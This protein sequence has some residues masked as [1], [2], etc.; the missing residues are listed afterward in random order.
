MSATHP[1]AVAA[2][3]TVDRENFVGNKFSAV[4]YDDENEYFS[5]SNNKN[6]A[7]LP[8]CRGDENK[9]MRRFNRRIFL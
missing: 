1:R 8:V 5:T 4:P 6:E 2:A 9:T 7:T 3:S